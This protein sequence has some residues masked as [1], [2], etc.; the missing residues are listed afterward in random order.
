MEINNKIKEIEEEIERLEN[1][2]LEISSDCW[3]TSQMKVNLFKAEIEL[4]LLKQ[5]QKEI[6]GLQEEIEEKFDTDRPYFSVEIKGWID[7]IFKKHSGN[8]K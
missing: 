4:R 1:L 6:K 7:K 2:K 8:I 3:L 5:F